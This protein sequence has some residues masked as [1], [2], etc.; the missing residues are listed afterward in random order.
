MSDARK[1]D[2]KRPP[3]ESLDDEPVIDLVDEVPGGPADGDLSAL[4]K[5]LLGLERSFGNG[6]GKTGEDL[7]TF[8]QLPDLNDLKGFDFEE[9][10]AG[11]PGSAPLPPAAAKEPLP[12]GMEPELDWLLEED[13]P[14][15]AEVPA[16]A[17][18]RTDN[19]I[20]EIS[21][22]DEQFLEAEEILDTPPA[23]EDESDGGNDD[24]T[25]ELLNLDDNETDNQL[26]WFDDLDKPPDHGGVTQVGPA[27]V[28]PLE[29]AGARL[30]SNA[31]AVDTTAADLFEAFVQSG[32][33][34]ADAALVTAGPSAA[35]DASLTAVPD[36]AA[37]SQSRTADVSQLPA[38]N[39]LT[40]D[41]IDAAVERVITRMY[42][43][44]IETI[45]RQAIEKAVAK[46]IERLKNRLLEN[47][48]DDKAP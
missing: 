20:T 40:A 9:D 48:P 30:F 10:D 35:A 36:A 18:G 27:G 15:P 42:A 45:I 32:R 29:P 19:A 16:G 11:R 12:S 8:P 43:G 2:P 1:S 24:E 17:A 21:E 13:A 44:T 38:A 34:V 23:A 39:A 46:E 5:N 31:P 3:I 26:V 6:L 28:K 14:A 33:P 4:E 37:M 41:Q 22:F 47:D 7:R 25:L